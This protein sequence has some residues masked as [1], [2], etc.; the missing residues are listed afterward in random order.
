VGVTRLAGRRL[1]PAG[2]AVG[3]HRTVRRPTE[4]IGPHREAARARCENLHQDSQQKYWTGRFKRRRNISSTVRVTVTD[5]RSTINRNVE[6]T[7]FR[8]T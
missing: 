2:R 1:L 5:E 7:N 3:L 4:N 8:R 6:A